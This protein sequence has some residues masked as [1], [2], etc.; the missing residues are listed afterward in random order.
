MNVG[1][2][3]IFQ[4]G[5]NPHYQPIN[6]FLRII[7]TSYPSPHIPVFLSKNDFYILSFELKAMRILNRQRILAH[8]TR[9]GLA[10]KVRNIMFFFFLL[11]KTNMPTNKCYKCEIKFENQQSLENH[12]IDHAV[13]NNPV[14]SLSKLSPEQMKTQ[15][16]RVAGRTAD[17]VIPTDSEI[18]GETT[19]ESIVEPPSLG[20]GIVNLVVSRMEREIA[21]ATADRT[22]DS[23]ILLQH[24][25]I[26]KLHI[27]LIEHHVGK[28]EDIVERPR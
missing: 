25:K 2:L 4:L 9:R 5:T 3:V 28:I 6:T 23:Q 8:G 18:K 22:V 15:I 20:S 16:H 10:R 12:L 7:V 1:L 26:I 27:A 24:V 19:S 13:T 21:G 11:Q 17:F 14:V